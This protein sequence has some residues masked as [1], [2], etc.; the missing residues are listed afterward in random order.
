[1]SGRNL[2]MRSGPRR[3]SRSLEIDLRSTL[4]PK[5]NDAETGAYLEN[6]GEKP[7]PSRPGTGT[8]GASIFGTATRRSNHVTEPSRLTVCFC[9]LSREAD[10]R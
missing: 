2:R 3:L 6:A 4:L 1:M 7:R 9:C 10:A 5:Q 8:A